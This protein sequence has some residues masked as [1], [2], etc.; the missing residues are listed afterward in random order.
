MDSQQDVPDLSVLMNSQPHEEST[1]VPPPKEGSKRSSVVTLS[2]VLLLLFFGASS[3]LLIWQTRQREAITRTETQ[4]AFENGT[5]QENNSAPQDC[6]LII[7]Y[8]NNV[9]VTPA[10]ISPGDTITIGVPKGNAT[11]ARFKINNSDFEVTEVK[12]N[13][14]FVLEY[15]FPIDTTNVVIRAERLINEVWQ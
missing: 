15:T 11:R 1:H 8:K 3:S 4:A 2:L 14:E 6:D 5:G 13:T 7:L 12:D 10:D 9:K